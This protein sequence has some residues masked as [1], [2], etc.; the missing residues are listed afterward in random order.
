M[1]LNLPLVIR[2]SDDSSNNKMI[3]SIVILTLLILFVISFNNVDNVECMSTSVNNT[4]VHVPRNEYYTT[5]PINGHYIVIKN[6]NKKRLPIKKIIVVGT[7][8][9]LYPI[10]IKQSVVKQIGQYGISFTFK[11]PKK[12]LIAQII[13]DMNYNK[14]QKN[15]HTSIVEI[16]DKDLKT[17][18]KNSDPLLINSRYIYV[19][20]QKPKIIHDEPQQILCNGLPGRAQ[21]NI[22]N[23][24]LQR[25]NWN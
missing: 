7:N 5:N 4:Y 9:Q 22:L 11:L 13:I 24:K 3:I 15:M 16:K 10:E 23:F 19:Y 17:K 21:E 12:I 6:L 2:E 14:T 20:I 1:S 25:D 8:R 18:W